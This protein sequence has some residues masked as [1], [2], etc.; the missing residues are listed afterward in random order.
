MFEDPNYDKQCGVAALEF[1]IV[2][3]LLIL[4]FLGITEFGIAYYNKQVLTNASREGARAGMNSAIKV[5]SIE[6]IVENYTDRLINFGNGEIKDYLNVE[7]GRHNAAFCPGDESCNC[8]GNEYCLV[9]VNFEHSY[10]VLSGF[11]F[12]GAN[13]GQTTNIGASTSMKML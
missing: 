10:L 7:I 1:A 13:F 9:E 3:P 8:N 6:H 11:R 5:N 4:L 12:F 2:L